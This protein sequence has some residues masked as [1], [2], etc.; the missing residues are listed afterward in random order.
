[1]L[2]DKDIAGVVSML[3]KHIDQWFVCTLSLPRGARASDLALILRQAGV[4]A[5]R[6][7]ENPA[8]AYAAACSAAAEND[9]IVAF[10]SFH[11]VADVIAARGNS[12]A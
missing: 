3:A 9:R 1:M 6:E 10:G 5:V 7:F 11:T 2:R 12:K 8:K 4:D